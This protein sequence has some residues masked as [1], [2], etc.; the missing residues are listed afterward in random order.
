[1]FRAICRK[2]SYYLLIDRKKDRT[3]APQKAAAL[4]ETYEYGGLEIV[5]FGRDY[6]IQRG[7]RNFFEEIVVYISISD[8]NER[9]LMSVHSTRDSRFGEE[10]TDCSR[11]LH[12]QRD[13]GERSLP[14]C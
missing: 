6:E 9:T 14:H 4:R 11:N 3:Y 1:V 8:R 7:L 5:E 13:E 2:Y 12:T 10:I